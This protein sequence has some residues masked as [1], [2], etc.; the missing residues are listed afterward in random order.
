MNRLVEFSP[1]ALSEGGS[2]REVQQ[3][4]ATAPVRILPLPDGRSALV[5]A[6]RVVG[7]A[8]KAEYLKPAAAIV[9]GTR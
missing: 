4:P 7:V 2:Y 5:V 6:G 8:A 9:G 1:G 3:S